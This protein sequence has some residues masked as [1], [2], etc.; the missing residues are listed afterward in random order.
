MSAQ[1]VEKDEDSDGENC[2]EG[3][4]DKAASDPESDCNSDLEKRTLIMGEPSP[5]SDPGSESDD[6]ESGSGCSSEL[7]PHEFFESPMCGNSGPPEWQVAR[8][9]AALVEILVQNEK[10]L[11]NHPSLRDYQ[12]HCEWAL[13]RFGIQARSWLLELSHFQEFVYRAKKDLRSH[14]FIRCAL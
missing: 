12:K 3:S 10:Q 14:K 13:S 4:D 7:A 1:D 2:E 6:A 8:K 9:A 5:S 11:E